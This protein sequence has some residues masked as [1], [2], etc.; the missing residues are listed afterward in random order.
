MTQHSKRYRSGA[1]KIDREKRYPLGEAIALAIAGQRAKFDETVEMAIR[2]NVDPRQAD[3][4]VRGTV[5][6]PNG[7]GKSQRVLVFAKGEKAKEAEAAGA[8]FIGA[9]DLV[10]KIQEES[11]LDF[12]KVVATPDMMAQ[13]GRIGRYSVS[14]FGPPR[15]AASGD[16][17][18]RLTRATGVAGREALR[19][20]GLVRG[21]SPA[22]TARALDQ[23][24]GRAVLTG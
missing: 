8:D 14:V 11:W 5:V 15:R 24:D 23:R 4:N 7:I 10:K 6:L 1:E 22:T 9:E 12:D 13:V 2:L 18:A 19:G 17:A 16:K 20:A 21:S 3:Q